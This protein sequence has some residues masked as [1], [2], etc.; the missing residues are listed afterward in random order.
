VLSVRIVLLGPPGAGKGT[1]AVVLAD[2]MGLVHIASGDLLRKHQ[3]RETELGLK[4][5]SY[6]QSGLLV[7]DDLVI[8]MV[9]G[10]IGRDGNNMGVVL[11]GFPR[12]LE[13][14]KALDEAMAENGIDLAISIGVS[15]PELVRRL[16]GR[17]VCR[18][19]QAPYHQD[20]VPSI[21]SRCGGELYQRE[22]DTI[23]AIHRRLVVYQS[24]TAPLLDYYH[25]Q[26]K[27]HQVD[28]GREVDEVTRLV[29]EVVDNYR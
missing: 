22:D 7:P 14:A 4:A 27:L 19:C 20:N 17:L 1:Q 3:A 21:C 6:M 24:E 15:E 12:T 26:G 8:A 25:Q 2:Q 23:E 29:I 28:G 16:G 9:L 10:E 5:R 11:D 18:E 13:Q